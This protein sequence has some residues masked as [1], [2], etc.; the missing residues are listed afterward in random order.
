LSNIETVLAHSYDTGIP[1]AVA[2]VV[3]L[4]DMIH[5]VSDRDALLRE[6]HRLLKPDGVLFVGVEHISAAEMKVQIEATRLFK[7]ITAG[8]RDLL[9]SRS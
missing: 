2:D 4:V 5:M 1:G 9:L 8:G 3:L 6:V 7:T